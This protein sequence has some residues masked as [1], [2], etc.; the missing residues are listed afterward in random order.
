[1]LKGIHLTLM[2]GPAVLVAAPKV[3]IDSLESV[4]VSSS[5]DRSGF[6][7]TFNVSKKSPLLTS[8]LPG[9]YFDPMIT[10][11]CIVVT[12]NGTPNVLMDGIITRQEVAPGNGPGG[13]K[14][15][16]T[17]EDLS[18]LMDIV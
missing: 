5:K 8:M 17:G 12:V 15:T 6:Q 13:S 7:L 11:V 1:M 4:Q 18:V 9:G 16:V 14:L 3:V 10:R 2:I